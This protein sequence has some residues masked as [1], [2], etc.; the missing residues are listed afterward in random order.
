MNDLIQT[1]LRGNNFKD[2]DETII[3]KWLIKALCGV[4]LVSDTYYIASA[5]FTFG[6]NVCSNGLAT[7]FGS[8]KYL[9]TALELKKTALDKLEKAEST[10]YSEFD[11][12]FQ[13]VGLLAL[14]LLILEVC[15]LDRKNPALKRFK[16]FKKK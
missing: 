3:I 11:E 5:L 6:T 13:A 4:L 15:I 16:L 10:I 9:T 8:G 1:V 12:Q 2:F 7:L 14:L